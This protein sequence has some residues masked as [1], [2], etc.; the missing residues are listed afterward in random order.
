M[1]VKGGISS[2]FLRV[3]FQIIILAVEVCGMRRSSQ[4]P[5][6]CDIIHVLKQS[7]NPKKWGT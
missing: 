4:E 2:R 7:V 6:F 1:S 5:S 3:Q